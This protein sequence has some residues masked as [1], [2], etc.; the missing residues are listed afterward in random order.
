MA[1][2]SGPLPVWWAIQSSAR[3]AGCTASYWLSKGQLGSCQSSS[4]P[5]GAGA[6][7]L[8]AL[9][10][11]ASISQMPSC[12]WPTGTAAVPTTV[13]LDHIGRCLELEGAVVQ[14]FH[15]C[16]SLCSSDKLLKQ[17][18]WIVPSTTGTSSQ[19]ASWGC[20]VW[21]KHPFQRTHVRTRLAGLLPSAE[22]CTLMHPRQCTPQHLRTGVPTY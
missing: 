1:H 4:P 22:A 3:L 17:S 12:A 19:S 18:W 11:S 15:S 21:S 10:G 20:E 7:S 16:C 6:L 2:P 13:L 8:T 9:V 5:A 14:F